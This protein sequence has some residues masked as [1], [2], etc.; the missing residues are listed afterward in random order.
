MKLI[1]LFYLFKNNIFG[2]GSI[3]LKMLCYF[4]HTFFFKNSHFSNY[5]LQVRVYLNSKLNLLNINRYI[6]K[7]NIILQNIKIFKEVLKK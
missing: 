6:F 1:F 2:F 5:I 7:E 4:T 3:I